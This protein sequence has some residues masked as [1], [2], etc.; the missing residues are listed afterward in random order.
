MNIYIISVTNQGKQISD[1]LY[2]ELSKNPTILSITQYHKQVFNS[3]DETFDKAD[4]II[5]IMA[6]GI[7]I[8]A[9]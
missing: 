3:I 1:K 8:R 4:C 2:E 7:M 6:S 5:G 9:I